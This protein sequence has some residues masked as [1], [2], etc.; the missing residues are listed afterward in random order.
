M[1]YA[2]ILTAV[3]IVDLPEDNEEDQQFTIEN[4]RD[5]PLDF[6]DQ[7]SISI[8]ASLHKIE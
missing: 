2:L 6:I 3:K 5:N 7:E 4:C 8:Q 1:R